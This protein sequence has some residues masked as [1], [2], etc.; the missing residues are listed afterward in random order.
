MHPGAEENKLM[1]H[2]DKAKKIKTKRSV[3]AP[4][5]PTKKKE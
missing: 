1:T 4:A 3:A 5:K 2:P